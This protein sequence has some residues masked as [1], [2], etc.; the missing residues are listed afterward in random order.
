MSKNKGAN[1]GIFLILQQDLYEFFSRG[2]EDLLGS[3]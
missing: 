3:Y 1:D 2:N